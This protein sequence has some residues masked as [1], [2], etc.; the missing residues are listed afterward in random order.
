M[1]L[2]SWDSHLESSRGTHLESSR[3]STCE[4][5]PIWNLAGVVHGNPVPLISSHLESSRGSP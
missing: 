1:N 2:D 3:G 4:S 5:S